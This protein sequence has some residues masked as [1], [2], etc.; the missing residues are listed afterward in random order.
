M[1]QPTT[2]STAA[3]PARER[4][5]IADYVLLAL[6]G[7]GVLWLAVEVRGVADPDIEFALGI[8]VGAAFTMGALWLLYTGMELVFRHSNVAMPRPPRGRLSPWWVG[9]VFAVLALVGTGLLAATSPV[10]GAV[11]GAALAVSQQTGH[12]RRLGGRVVGILMG[13]GVGAVLL[14]VAIV[15]GTSPAIDDVGLPGMVMLLAPGVRTTVQGMSYIF[16]RE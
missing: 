12:A 5:E 2:V 10:Q 13:L 14:F 15:V 1:T 16:E 8:V 11:A 9:L 6:T 4:A 7:L 3:A